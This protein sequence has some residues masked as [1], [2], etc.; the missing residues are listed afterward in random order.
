MDRQQLEPTV[1]PERVTTQLH[2]H[3]EGEGR[4]L[5][6]LPVRVS[7]PEEVTAANVEFTNCP[8]CRAKWRKS[9]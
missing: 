6:G 7:L 1:Q 3:T 2:I 9:A 5:C 8:V 4:F